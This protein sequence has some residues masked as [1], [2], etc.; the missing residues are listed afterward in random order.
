LFEI[1]KKQYETLGITWLVVS[2]SFEANILA[3]IRPQGQTFLSSTAASDQDK[4]FWPQ[5]TRP[6]TMLRGQVF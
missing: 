3:L 2:F 5:R 6:R 4:Y 1:K